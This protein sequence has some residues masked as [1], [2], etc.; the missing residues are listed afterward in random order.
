M[1]FQAAR[2]DFRIEAGTRFIEVGRSGKE[3][4]GQGERKLRQGRVG[5]E[6]LAPLGQHLAADFAMGR[7]DESLRGWGDADQESNPLG[8]SRAEGFAGRLKRLSQTI[9]RVALER[10]RIGVNRGPL[11]L[12]QGVLQVGAETVVASVGPGQRRGQIARG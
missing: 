10:L 6:P 1:W 5:L 3:V 9:L 7:G 12:R 8:Q 4:I 2:E 11:P